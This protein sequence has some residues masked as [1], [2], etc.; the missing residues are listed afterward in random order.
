MSTRNAR[1][2]GKVAVRVEGRGTL[3]RSR[4]GSVA[5]IDDGSGSRSGNRAESA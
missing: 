5:R 1:G 4:I 2:N 3:H